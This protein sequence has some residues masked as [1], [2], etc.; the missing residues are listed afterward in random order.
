VTT[1]TEPR[2]AESAPESSDRRALLVVGGLIVLLLAGLWVGAYLL[3]GPGVP[4]GTEV[5]GVPIGGMSKAA[6]QRTLDAELAD[7]AAAPLT[8][9][10][11]D[12]RTTLDPA[13]AGLALDA[14]ATVEA[15]GERD[16]NPLTLLGLLLDGRDIEPR[17]AVDEAALGR[18]VAE[19]A[20]D[21]DEPAR[22][23]DV[24]FTGGVAE[25]VD[26]REGR[27]LDRA[28][29]A[30]ALP[31]AYL[32]EPSAVVVPVT[33]VAPEV[34]Q[35]EVD[36]AMA[37]FAEPAMSGP[38]R[39]RVA[40]RKVAVPPETF[41]PHLSM[42]ADRTGRLRP[43]VDGA[44][45]AEELSAD[46]VGVAREPVNATFAIADGRPTVVPA[47][48]GRQVSP[49]LLAEAMLAV[50]PKER[51]RVA[52][53]GL[54]RVQP[55][56]TT[57]EAKL[58]GIVEQ[59]STF[60]TY[61]PYAAYRLQ[62]IHRAADLIDGD[63]VRPGE[64]WSLNETVGKR[65]AANGFAK[66]IV[67]EGGRFREAYGGGVSQM[68]TTTFNAVFFAGLKDV[69]HKPH[70]FYISRYPAGREATVAWNAVDLRFKNNSG[71]GILIDT[72]Y[73]DSSVTVTMYGTKRY[74][75]IESVSGSP[76]NIVP[77]D[78]IYDP[79]A[80]CVP[81]DGVNGFD[82]DVTRL[83]IQDGEVVKRET[84]HTDYIP[85]DLVYCQPEPAL[86]R[87]ENKPGGG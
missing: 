62:N 77:Y 61:Y 69:E 68:A 66:G 41:A 54:E 78:T 34:G 71:H 46:L 50:L 32:V 30:A 29:T 35:E 63:I 2:L 58:L 55:T 84:F 24:V 56:F 82:I 53:V 18:A 87:K 4:R 6:A 19:I 26:P 74:D 3:V 85:T 72:S 28:A 11:D 7:E 17:L 1:D 12:Q 52:R 83:F 15:A 49:P 39:L 33:V 27:L 16:A 75:D 76:Y 44:G 5:L 31:A 21:I 10:A 60:T 65:T 48:T 22:E 20:A 81:Q 47:R 57:R 23:G 13:R 14:A 70:S 38:V 67:I 64:V 43:Q 40:G 25:P 51:D 80:D 45:L 9:V 42:A 36:R 73:T 86:D 79:G 59:V 37:D 8:V